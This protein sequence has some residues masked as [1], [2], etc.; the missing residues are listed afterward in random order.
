MKRFFLIISSLFVWVFPS[1]AQQHTSEIGVFGGC[2]FYLGDLNPHGFFNQFTRLGYGIIYR[3]NINNR[4]AARA[5][6]LFGTLYADD[7]KS[8]SAFQRERNLNFQSPV[9]EISGQMEFNFQEYEIGNDKYSFSP[10]IFGGIGIFKF[11]PQ[12]K[13]GDQWVDL[14]PLRTEGQGT[15][16]NPNPPYHLIQPCIPFGIG[17]K[18]SF[19]QTL[20]LSI[21]WG[22]RKTFTGYLDDVN[23]V[24]PNPTQLAESQG[25]NAA[26]ALEMSNRS[27]NANHATMVGTQRGNGK[28]DWYSFAGIILSFHPKK[29]AQACYE[30]F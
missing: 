6:L 18:T 22:M 21:E 5:N 27:L 30:A 20:C 16:G 25:P 4:F 2:S 12:G 29:L 23:G 19:S 15:Q 10:Y 9:D 24:Y 7:S 26:L 14:Q 17:I 11:N 8:S 1:Y 13:I 28:N 3:Y